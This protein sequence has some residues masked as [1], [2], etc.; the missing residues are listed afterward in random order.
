MMELHITIPAAGYSLVNASEVLLRAGLVDAFASRGKGPLG[1]SALSMSLLE[2]LR[3]AVDVSLAAAQGLRGAILAQLQHT[4]TPSFALPKL[5]YEHYQLLSSFTLVILADVTWRKLKPL[6]ALNPPVG[7]LELD[8]LPEL[9]AQAQDPK[10]LATTLLKLANAYASLESSQIAG[11]KLRA[12]AELAH[13][14]ASFLALA[15]AATLTY[16]KQSAFRP[17]LS[18]LE[19]MELRVAGYPYRGL[20]ARELAEQASGLLPVMPD[21]IVGNEAF[22]AAGMRL[23]RDVAAYDLLLKQNP[24]RVNP[25]LFGLGKPGCGKTVTAHAIGN[26]FMR[27]CQDRGIPSKFIVIQRTDWASSYQN[28]SALNLVRI[29]RE[30]VYGFDGVC[31]VYWPDIDTAFASRD[32]GQLRAEEKNNLGAVFGI[33][34]GTLLPKDGKW[35]MLCD[36]NTMHMDEATISRI[37]QNP[38]SV[39]GPTTPVHYAT[40]MRDLM[41]KDLLQFI[42]I[43]EQGWLNV[44]RQVAALGLSGRNVEAICNNLRAHIQDF[45]LPD[46]YFNAPTHR[47][48]E[49]IH[50]ATRHVYREDLERLLSDWVT[51]QRDA[52]RRDEDARFSAEVESIIRRLNASEAAAYLRQSPAQEPT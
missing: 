21:D 15:R 30:E 20:V 52:E 19:A 37:A 46:E 51:F 45:D 50:S 31:G 41:L 4:D 28:A 23:A 11:A 27:F 47:R 32:S 40:M 43:D 13:A 22:L 25:V 6:I 14:I 7:E 17:L 16:A 18:A 49:L 5:E 34:D 38:M 44:G 36:A 39:E 10:V 3:D 42:H 33:F 1:P 8:G 26:Y 2:A 48:Q 24:K 35:F 12:E 9:L 29:F